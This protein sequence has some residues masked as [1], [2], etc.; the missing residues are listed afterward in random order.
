[1]P[2]LLSKLTIV[3]LVFNAKRNDVRQAV[4]TGFSQVAQSKEIRKF[5]ER[6]REISGKSVEV[7]AN[8]LHEHYLPTST[9]IWTSEIT[10]SK[11]PPFSDKLMPYLITT[12][13]ASG[14]SRYGKAM[15]VIPRRDIG[16]KYTRLIA[17]VA[18]YADDGAKIM[19]KNV[20]MEQPPISANRKDLAK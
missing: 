7:F 17:E 12:L 8:I 9:M 3:H 11:E 15:S 1:M 5:S 13:I 10:D 2:T 16:V 14:I 18:Q 6:G 20:W 4:I 19:I